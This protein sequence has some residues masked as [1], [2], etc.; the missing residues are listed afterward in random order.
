ML[1][2]SRR[3]SRASPELRS[4]SK[5]SERPV[6]KCWKKLFCFGAPRPTPRPVPEP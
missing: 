5:L 4:G 6:K 1:S 2:G 3:A